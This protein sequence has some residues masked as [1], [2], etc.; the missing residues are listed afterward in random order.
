MAD[1]FETQFEGKDI[2]V[3]G[4]FVSL[5]DDL[6]L[7]EK[8]PTLRRIVIGAG[9]DDNAFNTD[10]LDADISLILVD[11]NGQTRVDEDFVFYNCPE[12]LDGAVRH[13]GDNRT[14]AGDGDDENISVDLEG[15]PFDVVQLLIVL[16]IYKGY[17]KEQNLEMLRNV[18]VRIVNEDDG[19]ELVRYKMDGDLKEAG[20][21]A[22]LAAAV[23]REGP[24]WHFKPLCDFDAGDLSGIAE[25]R[26]LVIGAQ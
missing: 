10:A 16:S 14:G 7:I 8:N 23:N 15:V 18:Y 4:N 25:K 6:N 12:A 20:Q 19:T 24:K 17:E 11:K 13:H 22:V 26:G 5:G 3:E 2:D 9:W 1:I 21:T